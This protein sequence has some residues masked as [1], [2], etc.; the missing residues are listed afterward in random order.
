LLQLVQRSHQS[1]YE[2]RLSGAGIALQD[3]DSLA[4]TVKDEV[5]HHFGRI[6]LLT[7]GHKPEIIEY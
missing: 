4:I 3:E 5:S 7:G 1:S 2:C 6:L